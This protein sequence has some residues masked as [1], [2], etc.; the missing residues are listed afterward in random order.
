MNYEYYVDDR[1]EVCKYLVHNMYY[2]RC[3]VHQQCMY[4]SSTKTKPGNEYLIEL[5]R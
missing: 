5:S 2:D 1:F 4:I 3:T